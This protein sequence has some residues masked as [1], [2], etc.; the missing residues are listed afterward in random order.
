MF[1]LV[2]AT[3]EVIGVP[4][5]LVASWSIWLRSV[6]AELPLW[7]NGLALAALSLVSVSWSLAVL[8][9]VSGFAHRQTIDPMWSLELSQPLGLVGAIL[10]VA[11]KGAP[12]FLALLAGLLMIG[13]W[14][15]FVY[16]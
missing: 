8:S 7:R 6:R 1:R 4:M 5:L 9:V 13:F 15:P 10:A 11:L 2:M 14:V 16:R 12:R 3:V